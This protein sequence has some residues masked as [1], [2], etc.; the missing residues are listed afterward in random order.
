MRHYP[1][2]PVR[3]RSV[4]EPLVSQDIRDKPYLNH[5]DVSALSFIRSQDRYFF[6]RHYR[7]GLRSHIMEVLDQEDLEKETKGLDVGGVRRYPRARPVKMLRLFRAKFRNL[8][9]ALA[10]IQR[11]KIIG[12]YLTPQHVALSNEFLVDYQFDGKRD[13]ILCGL[14]EYVEGEVLN[15]WMSVDDR[16]LTSLF[17]RMAPEGVADLETAHSA[18]NRWIQAVKKDTKRFINKVK[19]LI[20]DVGHIPDLAGVGNL[21]VTPSGNIKLADINNISR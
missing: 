10:E 15:P 11:V 14:Q 16:H 2:P 4:K 19:H 18:T 8:G 3:P 21:L 17:W 1:Q 12:R 9:D 7:H 13:F 6:R 5:H 20:T